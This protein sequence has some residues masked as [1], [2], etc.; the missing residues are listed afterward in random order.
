MNDPFALLRA[1]LVS[2]AGAT[3]LPA[4]R[5]RR[6]WL[7]RSSR[8][9]SMMLA[10]VVITGS[11]AAAAFSLAGSRSQPLTGKVPGLIEPASVAGY[12][13]SIAVSPALYTGAVGWAS[14]IAYWTNSPRGRQDQGGGGGGGGYPTAT[15]PLFGGS[16]LSFGGTT[17]RGQTVDYALTS[18]DVMAL[19]FGNRTIRTFSSRA[20]PVGDRAAVFFVPAR[21][22]MLLP[23]WHPGMPVRGDETVWG[24]PCRHGR[25]VSVVGKFRFVAI[26]PLDRYGHVIASQP[27]PPNM[28]KTFFWQAPSAVT[29]TIHE[30]PY[31]GSTHPHPG[32]C[33]LAQHGLPDLVGEWGGT[34]SSITPV[35]DALGEVF[36][37]CV[38]TEYYL[39]GWPVQV[40]VLVDA[41]QPG[42]VLG[43]IPGARP[44]PGQPN[45]VNLAAMPAADPLTAKRVGDAWLVAEG[46]SGLSQRIT[47][48]NALRIS[49]LD[50]HHLG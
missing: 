23:G 7:P 37:S 31:H 36:V 41:R 16:I 5:G 49:K 8:P 50:V 29:P 2:A 17:T 33:A 21:G 15:N 44:V 20:L 22:P 24:C 38:N 19:R 6:R 43:P 30:S 42:Q 46:G 3:A 13:Y 48:L 18:P 4:P 11:A 12:H 32:A 28:P 40:A 9:L 45:M 39:H 26:L 27:A 47:V 35:T 1:E 10:A 34:I 14:F 25:A